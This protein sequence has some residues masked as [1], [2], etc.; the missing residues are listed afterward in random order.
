MSSSF[1]TVTW[2]S[3]LLSLIFFVAVLP[4]WTFYL[5]SRVKELEQYVNPTSNPVVY[6]EQNI[7]LLAALE[8]KRQEEKVPQIEIGEVVLTGEVFAFVQGLYEKDGVLYADIDPADQ[9]TDLECVFRAFD[10]RTSR[11]CEA[12]RGPIIWNESTS[13]IAF[14]LSKKADLAVYYNDG[15]KIGL[16]PKVI[17]TKNGKLYDYTLNPNASTT[18]EMYDQ[19]LSYDGDSTYRWNPLMHI[20]IKKGDGKLGEDPG[21]SYIS[22]IE[23]VWRP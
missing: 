22:S 16:K 7:N 21:K 23:E 13:T 11:S 20:V 4:V 8:A 1:T 17:N 10:L 2:Y 12:E 15:T 6:S 19:I 5:G 3:K 14:P 9:L 18:A